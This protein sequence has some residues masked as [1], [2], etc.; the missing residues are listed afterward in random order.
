M[1]VTIKNQGEAIKDVSVSLFNND[2][3]LAKT[4]IDIVDTAK[5]VFTLPVNEV[6]NGK[7]TI[8]DTQ[9]QFDNTLYFNLNKPAK[10][11]AL[12]INSADDGFLSK[13]YSNKEF[14]YKSVAFN[15]LNYNDIDNQNLIILNELKTIPNSLITALNSFKNDGGNLLIIPSDNINISSYNQLFTYYNLIKYLLLNKQEKKITKINFSHPLFKDVFNNKINNFQY[16]KVNSFYPISSSYTSTILSY[17]D[18]RPFLLNS[19]NLFFFHRR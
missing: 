19:N 6:I 3:L 5:T 10:I 2:I 17:E 16:P 14:N 12:S 9:L 4:S 7:I 11:N 1:T 18:G 13:V 15:Q 8:S